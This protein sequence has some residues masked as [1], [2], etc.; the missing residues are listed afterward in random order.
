MPRRDAL[1]LVGIVALGAMARTAHAGSEPL[2]PWRGSAL[3]LDGVVDLAGRPVVLSAYRG[4]VL[5]VNLWATWCAPCLEE[6][7]SLARL[8]ERHA[9]RGLDVLAVSIGDPLP[10]IE[11]FLAQHRLELPVAVDRDRALL[12]KWRVS[13]LP[14]SF[15]FDHA[16]RVRFSW[17]GARDWNDAA[18]D[19]ALDG[20]LVRRA[21]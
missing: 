8:R 10:R 12:A 19:D 3:R 11:R 5:L 13:V 21:R 17:V 16:G 20:L 7:P 4:R 15:L 1:R 2:A 14:S 6:M 9:A 18:V